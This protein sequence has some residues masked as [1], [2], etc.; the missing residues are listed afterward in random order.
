VG[1]ATPTV[2][3]RNTVAAGLVIAVA[4]AG[5]AWAAAYPQGA[6][7]ATV[8]RTLADCAAVVSLGLGLLPLLDGDRH[9]DEVLQRA[10][11]PLTA[12]AAAWVLTELTS[13]VVSAAQ[14]AAVP[15]AGLGLETTIGFATSTSP[16]RAGLLGVAAA[17]SVYAVVVGLPRNGSTNIVVVGLAAVG[18]VTRQLTGHFAESTLGGLAVAVHMLA[19]AVWCGVLAAMVLTVE[20]RGQWARMLPRFSQLSLACVAVLLVGGVLGAAVRLGSIAD[21]YTTGYGRVLSAKVVMT[22][23]L[24]VLGWRNRTLWLPAAATHR[25]SASVSRTRSR[26]ET[27]LMIIALALAAGLAVTG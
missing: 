26:V 11:A 17:A 18:V 7:T 4:A 2:T 15:L 8:V 6:L 23:V 27:A 19:A 13:L 16:G 20:H 3:H 14:T 10:S 9:R 5:A 24:V 25:A 12:A 22:A 21:L 1:G